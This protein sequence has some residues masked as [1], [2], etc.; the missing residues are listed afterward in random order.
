VDTTPS[1]ARRAGLAAVSA[2][3]VLLLVLEVAILVGLF[4]EPDWS[5]LGPYPVQDVVE[6]DETFVRVLG[7]KCSDEAVTVRGSFGWQRVDPPGFAVTLG[8]GTDQREAGCHTREFRNDVPTAVAEVNQPGDVWRILGS[9]TPVTAD[10]VEGVELG[11]ET[12]PFVLP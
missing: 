12:E 4:E 1:R 5:P 10:G 6:I 8:E 3:L 11:W 7:T 2:F 9:E